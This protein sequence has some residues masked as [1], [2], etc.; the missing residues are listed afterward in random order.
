MPAAYGG[1]DIISYLRSKYIIRLAVYHI[2]NGDISLKI[3]LDYSIIQ[4]DKLEFDEEV[5][6]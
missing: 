3:E 4:L 1:T 5:I 2:A 6:L